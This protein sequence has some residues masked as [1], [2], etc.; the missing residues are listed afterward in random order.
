MSKEIQIVPLPIS[1]KP[2]ISNTLTVE[3]PATEVGNTKLSNTYTGNVKLS[4][5]YTGN[6]IV[7]S[8][9]YCDDSHLAFNVFN[10]DTTKYWQCDFSGNQKFDKRLFSYKTP[11]I[12]NPYLTSPS[13]PSVYQSNGGGN[14]SITFKTNANNGNTYSGEWI[15]IQIP[16]NRPYYLSSTSILT[17]P[18]MDICT[19]P[20]HFVIL[21]SIDPEKEGWNLLFERIQKKE[22]DTSKKTP[23]VF[24]MNT[25][26]PAC[27]FRLIICS[28][29]PKNEIAQLTNWSLSGTIDSNMEAFETMSFAPRTITY[30]PLQSMWSSP[31]VQFRIENMKTHHLSLGNTGYSSFVKEGFTDFGNLYS[32]NVYIGSLIASYNQTLKSIQNSPDKY[33]YAPDNLAYFNSVP[34]INDV[35]NE[36]YKKMNETENNVYILGSITIATLLVFAIYLATD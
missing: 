35:L 33:D 9:S 1:I 11:Y 20:Q 21:G 32:G 10:N 18:K 2:F 12:Q 34:N 24:K 15:Q 36:D 4:D 26:K 28:L 14:D 27:Y 3:V 17:P 19:F 16:T 8:S 31:S 22:V 23:I 5:T 7:S 29:F 25:D 13:K 6:Y 30:S